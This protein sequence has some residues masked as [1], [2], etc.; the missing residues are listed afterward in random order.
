MEDKALVTQKL[1]AL[2]KT[3]R[4]YFELESLEY[5]M[6]GSGSEFVTA[7]FEDGRRQTIN[8]TMDSGIALIRDVIKFLE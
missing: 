2:L 7:T 3:T 8:V 4:E 5:G 1:F 6:A